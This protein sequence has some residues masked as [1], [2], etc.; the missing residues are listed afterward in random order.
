[1]ASGK[2]ARSARREGERARLAELPAYLR[3]LEEKGIASSIM[4]TVTAQVPYPVPV[5]GV[6]EALILW[7][8]QVSPG[9]AAFHTEGRE[10][11]G[12]DLRAA[13]AWACGVWA[14]VRPGP[15]SS[16]DHP[17][18]HRSFATALFV[19]PDGHIPESGHD[20]VVALRAVA[21]RACALWTEI[22]RAWCELGAGT[23]EARSRPPLTITN[24]R[25]AFQ[26]AVHRGE[27]EPRAVWLLDGASQ[28]VPAAD[29]LD[30]THLPALLMWTQAS[31]L[32]LAHFRIVRAIHRLRTS[33][34]DRDWDR[35]VG[36]AQMAA[37][38]YVSALL[39][40]VLAQHGW[41]S[42]DIDRVDRNGIFTQ[43]HVLSAHLNPGIPGWTVP[44]QTQV[45]G[46]KRD[47][48][49]MRNAV[50]HKGRTASQAQAEAAQLATGD[51]IGLLT[52]LISAEPACS[53]HFRAA[54]LVAYEGMSAAAR[55]LCE[56]DTISVAQY[57]APFDDEEL[58][59]ARPV[60]PP[61]SVNACPRA[62]LVV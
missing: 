21:A 5:E 54:R 32:E 43:L 9:W 30:D 27:D 16:A 36:D 51:L 59:Y 34:A 17:E 26:I 31:A 14:G 53:A 38:V 4:V 49:D 52:G 12:P 18:S 28:L 42:E 39:R 33:L 23:H 25:S 41:R 8:G 56:K 20:E 10:G 58:P 11:P 40:S 24:A 7:G 47:V 19:L 48:F 61:P 22:Y 3:Y 55:D 29:S 44:G 37:D 62:S 15:L 50:V 35:A 13:S 46:F 45:S 2:V 57:G 1:M 6:A 60:E